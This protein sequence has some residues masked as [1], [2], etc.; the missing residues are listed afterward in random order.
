MPRMQDAIFGR[1]LALITRRT[2]KAGADIVEL[3]SGIVAFTQCDLLLD[4]GLRKRPFRLRSEWMSR[5]VPVN[6]D[7][8]ERLDDA[9]LMLSLTVGG[10]AGQGDLSE[11]EFSALL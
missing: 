8:K 3:H 9:D 2:T 5:V 11:Q 7:Q 10:P 6:G 4:R 1:K